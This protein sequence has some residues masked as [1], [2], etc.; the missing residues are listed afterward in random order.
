MKQPQFT[1]L[2]MALGVALALVVA[3]ASL[4]PRQKMAVACQSASTSLDT[5]T[6]AKRTGKISATDL[7]SAVEVY[8]RAVVPSCVPVADSPSS[9]FKAAVADLVARAGGV[10]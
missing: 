9:A 7:R 3:C 1:L 5:L 6:L 10:Q 4:T 2:L 8:E